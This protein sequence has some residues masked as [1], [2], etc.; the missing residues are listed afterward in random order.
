MEV[1]GD[2]AVFTFG[3]FNPPTTGHEKLIDALAREQKKNPGAPMYVFPSH[4]NDP[5]KNPLPHALKV[6][7]MK[8]MFRK[9]AKNITVSSARNVFEV[10]T[11]LHNK[12]HRAVVMVVGSDRVDE[13]DRLLNEYNGVKGRHGYYGFDNIEVVSAGERD[14]DAEGV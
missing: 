13:F 8:K 10:A 6:A 12:G 3:R 2:T 4:S 11:F 9:Y 1:R 7:Y 14:P 5:K